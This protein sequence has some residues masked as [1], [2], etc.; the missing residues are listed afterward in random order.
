MNRPFVDLLEVQSYYCIK[1]VAMRLTPLHALIGPNDSGK[2]T[3]LRALG[4]IGDR[5][6]NRIGPDKLTLPQN[7]RITA[8]VGESSWRWRANVSRGEHIRDQQV[9]GHGM[10]TGEPAFAPAVAGTQLLRLEPDA[11][12]AA[13]QLIP[14]T[15]RIALMSPQGNGLAAV[16]DA[17]ASRDVKAWIQIGE[18]F[19]ALFDTVDALELRNVTSTEKQVGVRLKDGTRVGADHMSEG[20]LYWLAFASLFYAE[21]PA[22]MLI[23]EPE[24]GLHPARIRKVVDVLRRV[25]DTTQVLIATHSPLVIN[26]LQ[27]DEVSIVTRTVADGTI[28]TRCRRP[29]TSR[30]EARSTRSASCG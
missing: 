6:G 3:L 29:R 19:A 22:I 28:V 23:E 17:I 15:D 5:G 9:V 2:S 4:Y 14:A 25:S 21:H 10:P 16:C 1:Q 26:E 8:H 13:S 18:E 12:R 30:N 27:P 11:L 20:M 7:A 24:N